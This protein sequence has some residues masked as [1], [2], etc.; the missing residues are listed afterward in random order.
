M[1]HMPLNAPLPISEISF[2]VTKVIYTLFIAFFLLYILLYQ[3][4]STRK[5]V[6]FITSNSHVVHIG[7]YRFLFLI[8]F[9]L[10]SRFILRTVKLN[11]LWNSMFIEHHRLT[12]SWSISYPSLLAFT[13]FPG[14]E[15][16]L[17][18]LF[19]FWFPILL[20]CVLKLIFPEK[21]SLLLLLCIF[22]FV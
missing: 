11:L 19:S 13:F 5:L 12:L 15:M 22:L 18:L 16:I 2:T 20:F 1:P 4:L 9:Y 17:C 6:F 8:P 3:S 14:L 10:L 7:L 21:R